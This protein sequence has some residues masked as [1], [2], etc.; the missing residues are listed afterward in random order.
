MCVFF[1]LNLPRPDLERRHIN[2]LAAPATTESTPPA[3]GATYRCFER[4]P[5]RLGFQSTPPAWGATE[6]RCVT[7]IVRIVSIH[8]PAWGATASARFDRVTIGSFNPRP[9]VGGDARHATV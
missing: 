2:P 6:G 4:P 7:L 5:A 1:L 9:R 8:A 3:W